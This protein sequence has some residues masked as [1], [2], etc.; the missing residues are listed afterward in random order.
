[1]TQ[2]SEEL[3]QQARERLAGGVSHESRFKG[4]HPKYIER[5]E[6]ARKWEV[7]GKEYIDYAMGS[8]SLLLGHVIQMDNMLQNP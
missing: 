5:A 8:A 3:F 4:P 6:G 1:M 2:S 7:D